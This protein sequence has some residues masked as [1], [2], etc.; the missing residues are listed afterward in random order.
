MLFENCK[1]SKHKGFVGEAKAILEYSNRGFVVSKPMLDCDYD[2]IVDDGQ[3][4]KKVQVKTT[5]HKKNGYYRCNLRVMGGNKY[6]STVKLRHTEDWDLLFVLS[7]DGS[8]W[9]IPASEFNNKNQLTLDQRFDSFK[10][11]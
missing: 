7:D 2:L 6:S 10:Y 3:G 4:L 9:S 11:T 5:E 8:C 1:N